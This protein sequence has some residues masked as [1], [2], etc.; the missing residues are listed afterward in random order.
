MNQITKSYNQGFVNETEI[1]SY[2]HN[3]K[4]KELNINFR[5]F[6]K[7]IASEQDLELLPDTVIKAEPVRDNGDSN[8]GRKK[9]DLFIEFLGRRFFVS[10][11]MGSGNSVH[12]QKIE[13][14][15][16]YLKQ[17]YEIDQT[18][19]DDLRF[20]VWADGTLDGSAEKIMQDGKVIGRFGAREFKLL[21]PD[22][23]KNI[24]NFINRYKTELL[25]YVIFIGR[26]ASSVDYI[27]HGNLVKGGWASKKQLIE[28]NEANELTNSSS[29][30]NLCRATV[31]AWN[32]AISG[33][34]VAEK[35]RGVIQIK[36]GQMEKDLLSIMQANLSDKGKLSGD[37]AEYDIVRLLNQDKHHQFWD[38]LKEELKLDNN[39]SYY[40]VKLTKNVTSLLNGKKVLP[41]ADVIVIKAEIDINYLQS[42][43]YE[44]DEEN[45]KDLSYEIVQ[46]SGISVKRIDS[47][48]YT[49]TKMTIPTFCLYFK[50]Y[51]DARLLATS[52]L[53]Y[54]TE[55]KMHLNQKILMD[56]QVTRAE[57]E[58]FVQDNLGIN[59]T[60][61]E[62]H[63]LMKQLNDF[64]LLK[65]KQ[66]IEEDFDLKLAILSGKGV[67]NSPYFANFTY[68]EGNLSRFV[69]PEYII[70]NGSGRS[71]GIYTVII[72][73]N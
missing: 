70:T 36:Y 71:K 32:P 73:P 15:I 37:N 39:I 46:D 6:I 64:A 20:F 2:L 52:I 21:Y 33:S 25:E 40:L 65:T 18:V 14:F 11:K 3:K 28:Y 31:Q 17:N 1:A 68:T 69:M 44:L 57:L 19:C 12:Q 60:S 67:Y 59:L 34:D 8:N 61:L 16:D 54:Q 45:L 23:T 22:K 49:I 63:S 50:N 53:L 48:K 13:E 55:G 24:Q 56:N 38:V 7:F 41:K 5:E 29:A 26:Y 72:K 4:F 9:E 58:T 10:L 30:I 27:Y 43:N 35:K 47:T 66:L 51:R 42:K 62:D